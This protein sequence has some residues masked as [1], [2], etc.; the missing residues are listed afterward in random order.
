MWLRDYHID[1]LRFDMTPPR[2]RRAT[3]VL[4]CR[5]YRDGKPEQPWRHTAGA[6]P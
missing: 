4:V 2:R 1:G 3:V 5:T 6:K